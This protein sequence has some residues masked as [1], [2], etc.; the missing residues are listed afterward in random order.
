VCAVRSRADFLAAAAAAA[1]DADADDDDD[2]T[3]MYSCFNVTASSVCP[4]RPPHMSRRRLERF[5]AQMRW[6]SVPAY[7]QV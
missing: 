6:L 5:G 4:G 7:A 1:A 3:G 2:A